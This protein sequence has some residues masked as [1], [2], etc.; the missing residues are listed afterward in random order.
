MRWLAV[1]VAILGQ[2]AGFAPFDVESMVVSP[3]TTIAELSRKALRGEPSRLAWSPDGSTLYVQSRD[4][5]GAA[6]TLRHYQLRLNDRTLRPLD[7]EP[8]WAADYWSN[9]VAERAPGM[10]WLKIDVLEERTR[11][12]VA[13][14]TGG[15]ASAGA[16]TGSE[17]ASSFVLS[18]ITLS[19]LGVE[20]G[21]FMSDEARSGVTFG[22]GPAGS[23]AMAFVDRDGH[24]SL[25][26]KERRLRPIARTDGVL[27]PAWSP[28]G[29]YVVFLQ[30]QARTRYQLSSVA[31][32]RSMGNLQ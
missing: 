12:R 15:F 27:L 23:G 6:A 17:T 19:Y 30:K 26:D 20:I 16:S 5:V 2:G 32:L 9:K 7:V 1:A 11:Q 3:P 10:P 22:W 4:G 24:L 21:H 13:P 18:Y 25:V 8:D 31:I 28:D 14:F 29:N